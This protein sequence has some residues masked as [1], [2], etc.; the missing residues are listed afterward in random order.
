[1]ALPRWPES[2]RLDHCAG[3]RALLLGSKRLD[4]IQFHRRGVSS[5]ITE[6]QAL[7]SSIMTRSVLTCQRV[8]QKR[9]TCRHRKVESMDFE[10]GWTNVGRIEER[11]S[12]RHLYSPKA[13]HTPKQ[14]PSLGNCEGQEGQR[15]RSA[16]GEVALARN[17]VMFLRNEDTRRSS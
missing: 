8:S 6:D 16:D 12:S 5:T 10:V 3:A 9:T 13:H 4:G 11:G 7:R 15:V 17:E 14:I 2:D 1:M